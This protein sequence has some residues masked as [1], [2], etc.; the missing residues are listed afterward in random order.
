MKHQTRIIV[1]GTLGNLIE[2]FD[3]AICG[4]LSVYIAKYLIGDASKG[5]F[6]VFLTFFAGYLARPIGAMIMGLLSDIYG[7]KIILAGS[8]LSMGVATTFIGFIPPHTTIGIFSVI[9]LLVLRII[10]SFSCGA[11]YLN[12]SAYLVENAEASK[13]GYSGSWA[14]FGTMSGMLVAS[15]VALMVTYFTNHY[16]EHDW[17]IWRVP[18][19]LALLGSSIGLYI[20]LCIPESMEYIMYYADR[21]KPKFKS[22]LS[23]SINFIKNNKIQSLYVF[24][25]SCLGVTTTFQIYIY[26]PMQAHLYGH[27][28]DHEI[29]MSN[30]I[31]LIVLL[32]V[33]P[34]VGKLSDKLNREKIVIFASIGFLVLSQPF[35]YA[36]SHHDIY[37]LLLGQALIAIP[38]GAYY[39]TVPV[40]LSEMFPIK[41][42]CTVLSAIY[43]T[44]ASLSAGLAPLLSFILVRKTH[45]ASSPSIL[46]LIFVL[47]SFLLLSIKH[48]TLKKQ[49]GNP[50]I[51]IT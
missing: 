18:F 8:I 6:L 40:M 2:S 16:P 10:Q 26:G 3:M 4:L 46:I 49:P 38:A 24:V 14:S 35:F 34:L 48:S 30:I 9:T 51:Q 7:R 44:A 36:L 12:S 20:R 17:L 29:I 5:L 43:S 11:E 50:A 47:L 25:L 13:K 32:G 33:F 39:A 22:L 15:L 37:N 23:E 21:P 45:I 1:A 19:V 42:R 28:Q 31:S 41:L 27:F